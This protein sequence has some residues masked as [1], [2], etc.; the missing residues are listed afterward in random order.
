MG[1]LIDLDQ[2]ED[3]DL[4]P[5]K[6]SDLIID[7]EGFEGPLDILLELARDQ[8]VDLVHISILHLADQ[9]LIWVSQARRKNLELAADYL[10]MAA[11]LAYLKSRLLIPEQNDQEEPSAEEMAA[12]LA[13]QL[14][15]LE[16]MRNA[17]EALLERNVLG[18]KV[19]KRGQPE[20][21]GKLDEVS[22]DA[23]LYDLMKAYGDQMNKHVDQTLHIE[24]MD[25][26]SMDMAIERLRSVL[27]KIPQWTKLVNFLPDDL[28]NN[29]HTRS[30]IASTFAAA[31]EMARDGKVKIRQSDTF[32]PIYLQSPEE[33]PQ[34]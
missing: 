29:L 7:L 26:Y 33:E 3:D 32:G 34:K 27:G 14:Q 25:L 4:R 28:K 23:T 1:N 6:K 9:Y 21:F 5:K 2:H 15:R 19:H 13:F 16:S 30:A 8:K 11:W 31:L 20:N 10:V 18:L 24:P 22:Y 17:G 12:A